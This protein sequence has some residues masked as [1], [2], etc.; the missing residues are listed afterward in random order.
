MCFPKDKAPGQIIGKIAATDSDSGDNA[1]VSYTIGEGTVAPDE[2]NKLF[3][4]NEE[5]GV[6]SLV[7]NLD[8]EQKKYYSFEVRFSSSSAPF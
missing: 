6:I 5:T 7:E 3:K 1:R 4:L 2:V 8:N